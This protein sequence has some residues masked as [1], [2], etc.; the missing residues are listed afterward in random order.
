[1]NSAGKMAKTNASTA[2]SAAAAGVVALC[3][4]TI[5]T[6][7]PGTFLLFGKFTGTFTAGSIYYLNTTD[8]TITTTAPT[9][10]GH[11]VRPIGQALSTTILMVNPSL[12]WV[13]V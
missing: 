2:S 8:A 11:T 1:M 5:A 3:L 9:T 13:E 4:D 6:D 12:I 10:T 7:D